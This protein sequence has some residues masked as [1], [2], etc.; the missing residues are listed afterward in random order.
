M[1]DIESCLEELSRLAGI[2]KMLGKGW[3]LQI[4]KTMISKEATRFNELKRSLAGI[5]RTL[6]YPSDC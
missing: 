5:S 2:W 4:F 6:Y 1:S 3:T